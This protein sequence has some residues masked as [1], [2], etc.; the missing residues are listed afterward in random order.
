MSRL[1]SR[2]SALY[3]G[4][5]IPTESHNGPLDGH[6]R[7]IEGGRGGKQVDR[8]GLHFAAG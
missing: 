3:P 1:V 4:V 2:A 5:T 8:G 7:G 6:L